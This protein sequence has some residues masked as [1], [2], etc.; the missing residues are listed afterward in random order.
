MTR[1]RKK[2]EKGYRS[3]AEQRF[4]EYLEE[5]GIKFDYEKAT[6]EYLV[7]ETRKYIPDFHARG[8]YIEFKGLFDS[9]ARKKMV[10]VRD[11]NEGIDLRLVF[12]QDN[13]I[14][15]GS[16]T[17]YSDWAEANGFKYHVG[18]SLPKKWIKELK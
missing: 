16:K 18:I 17:R 10:R 12:M 13:P 15:K 5:Q 11:Q 8:I 6:F 7:H 9:D 4:A 3:K 2:T 1:R 14:R